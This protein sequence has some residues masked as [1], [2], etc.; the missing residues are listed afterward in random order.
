MF[1]KILV[2]VDGSVNS[3]RAVEAAAELAGK[4]GSALTTCHV[5]YIPDYYDTDL[6]S[7]LKDSVRADAEK[8]LAH[9]VAVAERSDIPADARLLERGHPADAI[10][11]LASEIGADL[12]VVGVRG[13]SRDEA[14]AMGS[15]SSAV[16]ERA[17]CS[18]LLA[19]H[20]RP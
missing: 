17:G 3:D 11:G 14:R 10:V 7:E 19:R 15:V 18:V 6:S 9:A 20:K 8:I 2:A 1:D 12:I 16:A 13:K 5:F 4:H